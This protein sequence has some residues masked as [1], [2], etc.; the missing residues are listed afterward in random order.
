MDQPTKLVPEDSP[1]GGGVAIRSNKV[2]VGREQGDSPDLSP[3]FVNNVEV[4]QIGT[5]FYLDLGIIRPDEIAQAGVEVAQKG[6][7]QGTMSNPAKLDFYVLQ[8]VAMSA[9]T[10][11]MLLARGSAFLV[12]SQRARQEAGE[13]E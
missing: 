9:H 13:P 2:I 5:D 12:G 6:G 10:F 4:L 8:R 11:E 7:T 1:V 3:L